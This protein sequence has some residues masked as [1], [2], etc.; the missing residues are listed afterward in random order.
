MSDEVM[1]ALD[2]LPQREHWA[3]PDDLVFA[4]AAGGHID[5][6]AVRRAF[7]D[8]AFGG[9]PSGARETTAPAR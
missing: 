2:G 8:A 6:M 1:A 7:N 3:A 5:L 9:T 4:A